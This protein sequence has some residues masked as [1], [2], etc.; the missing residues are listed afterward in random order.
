MRL[1][2]VRVRQVSGAPMS[3]FLRTILRFEE[4]K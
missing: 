4:A 3:G 1:G 2:G